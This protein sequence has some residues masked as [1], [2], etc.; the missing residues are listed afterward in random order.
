MTSDGIGLYLHIP[1]CTAKCG[2]CDFNSYAGH[3]HMIPSYGNTLLRDAALWAE[4]VAGRTVETV[5]FGGG[6]PSLT[7]VDQMA[8]I[9]TGVNGVFHIAP[10]AEISLEANP[11]SL[12]TEYL[13]GLR[14]LGFNRLSI[15]VQS[16][17][18]EELVALDRIH[19]GDGAREAYASARAAGF[20]NVNLDFIYGLSEQRLEA[21]Q[22]TLE[23]ALVL[24]PEHLSLYALTIEE[25]TPLARDVARGRVRAPDPDMQAEHY[26]WTQ[27]RL[28]RAGY[29]HYEISNWARAG[30]RC[31]H[32]LLYWQ[33]REYLGLGAGAHSFL[34]GVRFSTVL[35]PNRYTELVD[36]TVASRKAGGTAMLHVHGAEEI[37]S[38]LSMSDTLILGLRLIEGIDLGAFDRR[39]GRSVD[40]RHG[41]VFEEFVGYGLLERTATHLRLTARG[42][43]L[44]NELFQRL[45][46]QPVA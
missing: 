9:L 34:N 33:N 27:D 26:E 41:P 32:N 24:A 19:T 3:E 25:G 31:K 4:A 20:D 16:F 22:R 38:E 29:E 23:Q 36:E 11:G 18:D 21:W 17:D 30:R 37:T 7:P 10:D 43:L 28:V 5:F 1:F 40:E 8:Q 13:R 46:P 44:S 6:T 45:L 42:R 12:S 2:Y 39:H 14:S 35:L 15:G